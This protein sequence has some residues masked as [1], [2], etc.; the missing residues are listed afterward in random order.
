MSS[1]RDS[2]RA[3]MRST[4]WCH[5]GSLGLVH[6]SLPV[7]V[8]SRATAAESIKESCLSFWSCVKSILPPTPNFFPASWRATGARGKI[9]KVLFKL[10]VTYSLLTV[11]LSDISAP[12]LSNKTSHPVS[13]PLWSVLHRQW[14]FSASALLHLKGVT[15]ELGL[16]HPPLMSPHN[17]TA[18]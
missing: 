9:L 1:P 8:C 17:L 2:P 12:T 7:G 16:S 11:F 13:C 6:D 14:N 5:T 4:A 10:Y 3:W 15:P 18:P